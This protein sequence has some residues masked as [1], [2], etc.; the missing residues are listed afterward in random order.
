MT[1]PNTNTLSPTRIMEVG[2]AFWPA[3]TLLSAIKIGLFTKLGD[4]S[5]T[6]DEMR[7]ALDLHP[8]AVPDFPDTLVALHF[9]EK[10]GDGVDARYRNTAETAAF[11]NRNSP[12]F[13]GG[14]L[15][16]AN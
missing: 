3:K 8:R 10:D 15:E 11:L 1:A 2:M 9:L 4:G 13:M 5:M 12:T 16:M 6:A 14:F 7:E